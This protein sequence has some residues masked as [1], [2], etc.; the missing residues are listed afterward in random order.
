ML[1]MGIGF[2]VFMVGG[3]VEGQM[4]SLVAAVYAEF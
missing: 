1:V 4:C 3:G 2:L